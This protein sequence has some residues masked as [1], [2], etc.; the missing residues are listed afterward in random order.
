MRAPR[1]VLKG[2]WRNVS[3]DAEALKRQTW[4]SWGITQACF[5]QRLN[6]KSMT[7]I[8]DLLMCVVVFQSVCV[9]VGG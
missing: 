6:Y 1:N 7:V 2:G 4:S 8:C 5:L 3:T 9:C